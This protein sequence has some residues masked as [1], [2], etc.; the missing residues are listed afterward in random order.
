MGLVCDS[1]NMCRKREEF[2]RAYK[3]FAETLKPD[4]CPF[5]GKKW[6][7]SAIC[8]DAVLTTAAP[9]TKQPCDHNWIGLHGHPAAFE[10]SKCKVLCR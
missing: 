4:F 7:S 10:C 2:V 9:D 1:L 3:E 5:C 6:Y 8:D